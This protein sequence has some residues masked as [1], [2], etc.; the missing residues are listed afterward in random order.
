MRSD[1]PSDSSAGAFGGRFNRLRLRFGAPPRDAVPHM[2]HFN[3]TAAE[4]RRRET[5]ERSRG[6]LVIAA[7]MFAALFAVVSFRVAW[8][9]VVRPVAAK[10]PR[11]TMPQIA[12]APL[13]PITE[14]V[15]PGQRAM[16]VDRTGQPL[17]ISQPTREAF[18]D[19][20]AIGDPVDAVRK[21]KRVLPRLDEARAIKRLSDLNK[22]FVYIER[23]ITPDEEA[24]IN[25]LGI[26]SVI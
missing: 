7:G 2:E 21:L 24:R 19:P 14:T 5:M 4:R 6:R 11:D 12:R 18:A 13:K 15:L 1:P 26:P 8:V 20:S 3:V 22:H 9:T 16:I 25:N 23:Q 10:A 17:A